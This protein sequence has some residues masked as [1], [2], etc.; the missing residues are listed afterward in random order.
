LNCSKSKIGNADAIACSESIT[1]TP[2]RRYF[3]MIQWCL[4]CN[5]QVCC[6]MLQP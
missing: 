3:M 5:S 2:N 4:N 1:A 6:G